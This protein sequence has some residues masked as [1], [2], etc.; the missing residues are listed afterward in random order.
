M[1]YVQNRTYAPHFDMLY[2]VAMDA[3]ANVASMLS[4]TA[5]A[6]RFRL[7]ATNATAFINKDAS[8]GHV[9]G[10]WNGSSL[11]GHYIDVWSD[12]RQVTWVLED[13]VEG[14]FHDAGVV[15]R[16]RIAMMFDSFDASG[17]EGEYGVR[18]TFPYIDPSV[19]MGQAPGCYHNGGIWPW[20]NCVDAVSRMEHGRVAD[21][22][23]IFSK[24]SNRM[25]YDQP[26]LP[27]GGLP[28]NYEWMEG[29]TGADNGG[30]PQG[31]NAACILVGW[32][33]H[34]GLRRHSF[35]KYSV[36]ARGVRGGTVSVL[37]LAPE[38]GFLRVAVMDSG[39]VHMAQ[40]ADPTGLPP[41]E[42]TSM[43]ARV[44]QPALFAAAP[45]HTRTL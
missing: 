14:V 27:A 3:M 36:H 31:W 4:H 34:F 33:G 43:E 30:H 8:H 13:Q 10:L 17:S 32:R 39:A 24:M 5:D 38:H 40:L 6:A 7:L 20:L 23:R 21:G 18:E 1:N 42:A 2:A 19:T 16:D 29:E 11:S 22:Q 44:D 35:S 45:L 28:L 9:G 25:L 15:P 41:L 26:T 37:P 12:K